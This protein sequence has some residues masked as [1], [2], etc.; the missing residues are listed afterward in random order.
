MYIASRL[1]KPYP[2]FEAHV[3]KTL[4][5]DIREG[6]EASS[7]QETIRATTQAYRPNPGTAIEDLWI[8]GP[9]EGQSLRL[10]V[11]R[12]AHLPENAPM[13][14]DVHGGGFT[15]GDLDLENYRCLTLAEGTPCLV[16][17]VEYRT[18]SETIHYPASLLD[19]HAAYHWM[20]QHGKQLGGDPNRVGLHGTSAGGNLCAGL[21]LYLR[22]R[23]EQPPALTVLSCPAL[24]I[25]PTIST[26]QYGSLVASR[27]PYSQIGYVVYGQF[28]SGQTV[29]YYAIPGQCRDLRGLGP[30]MIITAEYDPLRDEG[31]RYALRLLETGIPCELLS[32]PRVTH[33]FCAMDHPL[34]RWI[35]RGIEASFRREFQMEITEF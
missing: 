7:L 23:G 15:G 26:S 29:P 17:S 5:T 10:R 22:D 14:L 3:A 2:G 27:R 35:H 31:L 32:A 1:L 6:A 34:T 16:A 11:Y 25:R 24:D 30:H 12:P 28:N 20:I 9:E 18:A 19:C 4:E 8:P 33:G 21:A 13:I